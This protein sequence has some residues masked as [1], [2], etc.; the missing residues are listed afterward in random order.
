MHHNQVS[1]KWIAHAVL[2]CLGISLLPLRAAAE[3]ETAPSEV[4]AH[5]TPEEISETDD[6]NYSVSD[7][8]FKDRVW[9]NYYGIYYGSSVTSPNR[10]QTGPYRQKDPNRPVFLKNFVTAG[11]DLSDQ[12]AI[13]ATGYFTYVPSAP[14]KQFQMQD[15]SLRIAN[16]SLLNIGGFN[17]YG[18]AR[19]HFAVSDNSRLNDLL[20]GFQSFHYFSYTFDD[21]RWSPGIYA[22]ARYNIYGK[23]GVGNDLD[24]YLAPS[25]NYSISDKLALT[26]LYEMGAS[27]TYGADAGVLD[28]EGTD[29]QPGVLWHITP[30]LEVNPYLNIYTGGRIALDNTSFGM[31]LSWMML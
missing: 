20:V 2:L 21:S 11:F 7:R 4:G 23:M 31:T 27:H 29:F 12:Y 26:F 13:A 17:W 6:A 18:D 30:S 25:L 3:T 1:W 16:N 10:Y 8:A 24:L 19:V 14:E 5:D 9:L 28:S 15:P 22:S